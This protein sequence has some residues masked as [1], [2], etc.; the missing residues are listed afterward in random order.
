MVTGSPR[1]RVLEAALDVLRDGESITLDSAARR[2]GMTKPGLMHHFPT[3]ET[4][5]IA[6]VDCVADRWHADLTRCL[7]ADAREHPTPVQRM[8]AYLE[9]ALTTEFDR[10]DLVMF[11]DARLTRLLAERWNERMRHW[12]SLPE[13]LPS[14]QHG[15]LATVRVIADG[16][17]FDT[18]TGLS[19]IGAGDRERI[20]AVAYGLLKDCT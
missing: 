1:D 18:A 12:L 11:A 13:D 20:R 6:L 17:W 16:L 3:K 8:T 19:P 2:V 7:P 5:M 9:C 4:L 14:K 15:A 10:T